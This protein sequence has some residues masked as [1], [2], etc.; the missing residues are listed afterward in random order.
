MGNLMFRDKRL[1]TGIFTYFFVYLPFYQKFLPAILPFLRFL[2]GICLFLLKSLAS[3]PS[4]KKPHPGYP[5]VIPDKK[6]G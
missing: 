5:W 3:L 4:G 6:C 2:I 1:S